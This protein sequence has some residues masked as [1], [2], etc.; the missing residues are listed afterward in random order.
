[1]PPTFESLTGTTYAEAIK[2]PIKPLTEDQIN[3]IRG[4]VTVSAEERDQ[5]AQQ[6]AEANTPRYQQWLKQKALYDQQEGQP[7]L[8][9]MM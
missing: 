4:T 1:M 3:L 7:R 8:A 6:E 2:R 9:G 5:A